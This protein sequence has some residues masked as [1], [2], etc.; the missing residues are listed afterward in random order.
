M[1]TGQDSYLPQM[2]GDPPQTKNAFIRAHRTKISKGQVGEPPKWANSKMCHA[3]PPKKKKIEPHFLENGSI[4]FFKISVIKVDAKYG[5][6][7][8]AVA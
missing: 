2:E 4:I 8:G 7:C 3:P 6:D 5:E 1:Q